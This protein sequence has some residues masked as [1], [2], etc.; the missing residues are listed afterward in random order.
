MKKGSKEILGRISITV[1]SNVIS[2]IASSLI[3]MIVP[4]FLSTEQYG[5]FQL[6]IFYTGYI[7]FAW[8]K[9]AIRPVFA[10]SCDFGRR[11]LYIGHFDQQC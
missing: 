8:L 9:A 10:Y 7:G 4:K 5:F 11:D 6:Y 3:I 2:L 1:F